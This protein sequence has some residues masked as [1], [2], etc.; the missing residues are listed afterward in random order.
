MSPRTLTIALALSLIA[1][2]FL[3]GA[4]V[5]GAAWLEGR[6]GTIAA[7]SLRVA[8]SEL[9]PAERRGF[10]VALRE[11][12]RSVHPLLEDG[13]R[14]RA[15]AATL[16]RQPVLDQAALD[17]ALARVR[18]DDLAVRT[19]VEQRAV[20]FAASLKPEDRARLADAM[21]RRNERRPTR[22]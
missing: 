19:A 6:P 15:E 14:A 3:G 21:V 10:R 11:A 9:S 12:R 22:N 2:L 18:S 5:G 4:L 20:A 8:G 7:G 16:L 13:R 17:A 1:N